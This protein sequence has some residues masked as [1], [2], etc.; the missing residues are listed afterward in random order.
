MITDWD[1]LN[2][3]YEELPQKLQNMKVL[4][5]LK[6]N[7]LSEVQNKIQNLVQQ[8]IQQEGKAPK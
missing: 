6:Q 3:K 4:E 7:I 2:Y 1:I 5:E 8:Q